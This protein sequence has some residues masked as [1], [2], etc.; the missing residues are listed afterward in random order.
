[1]P[2]GIDGG[3]DGGNKEAAIQNFVKMGGFPRSLPPSKMV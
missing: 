2:S 1:M 3:K